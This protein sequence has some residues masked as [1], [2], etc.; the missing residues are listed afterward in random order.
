MSIS[1]IPPG[2]QIPDKINVL[3]EI[4]MHGEPVKYEVDKSLETI[5]VDRILFTSM[6]YP[7]NYG[8]I[9][10]TLAE[11]GDPLDVLVLAPVPLIS[12]SVIRCRPVGLFN[13]AD[14]HGEDVKVLAV[15]LDEVCS[16]YQ[17]VQD[18]K[19]VPASL[20]AEIRH[21]FE[22]YKDLEP[23]KQVKVGDWS[24]IV[25]AKDTILRACRQYVR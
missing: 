21:F 23:G 18:I 20:R 2:D 8:Y 13:M 5:F 1:S 19:D 25:Q 12:G 10:Q 11:D 6:R 22:H 15:P 14:E 24:G 7:C 17:E 3:V 9:P 4:P 16:L